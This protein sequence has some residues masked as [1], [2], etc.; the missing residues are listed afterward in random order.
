MILRIGRLEA[1]SMPVSNSAFPARPPQRSQV[2]RMNHD[3]NAL[4][5]LVR[6]PPIETRRSAVRPPWPE[7]APNDEAPKSGIP[8]FLTVATSS[9]VRTCAVENR[10]MAELTTNSE[11]TAALRSAADQLDALAEAKE[12]EDGSAPP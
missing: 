1:S 4:N 6:P 2:M 5:S 10:A 11:T 8:E 7:H 9:Q 12:A 3:G